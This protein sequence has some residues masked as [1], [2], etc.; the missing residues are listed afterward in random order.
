MLKK[1]KKYEQV[2]AGF[3]C[4]DKMLE[5]AMMSAMS[6]SDLLASADDIQKKAESTVGGK[7]ETVVAMDDFAYKSHFKEGKSCKVEKNGQY[8]LA[9]QP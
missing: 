6:G 5:K 8:A 2:V 4:C 1:K 9:W 3:T 7:F